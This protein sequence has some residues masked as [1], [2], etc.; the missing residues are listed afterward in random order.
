MNS[1]ISETESGDVPRS[2]A[3]VSYV[4]VTMRGSEPSTDMN[5]PISW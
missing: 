3:S 1:A 5:E 2:G 4:A